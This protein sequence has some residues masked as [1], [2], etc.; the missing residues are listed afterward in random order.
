MLADNYLLYNFLITT[1]KSHRCESKGRFNVQIRRWDERGHIH[2]PVRP[3]S[4]V[5]FCHISSLT[6][7][8]SLISVKQSCQE[9]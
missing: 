2:P 8:L 3:K 9:V 6:D 7:R 4:S 5:R 1:V